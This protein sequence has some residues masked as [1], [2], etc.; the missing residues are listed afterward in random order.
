MNILVEKWSVGTPPFDPSPFKGR[1]WILGKENSHV[2]PLTALPRKRGRIKRGGANTPS[3]QPI[4]Q[5]TDS[6][7]LNHAWL[8]KIVSMRDMILGNLV[9]VSQIPSETFYERERAAF[10]LERL[11][12]S[13]LM[14]A[15]LDGS[16]NVIGILKGKSTKKRIVLSAS[17]DTYFD[18][19]VDHNVSVTA[20][21]ANGAGIANNSMGLTALLSLPD[22]I[23]KLKLEFESDLIFLATT[24]SLGKGDLGGMRHFFRTF[25]FELSCVLNIAGT[26][27]GRVDHYSQS[28]VRGDVSCIIEAWNEYAENLVAHNNAILVLNRLINSLMRIPLSKHPRTIL[29]IGI[30]KGGESYST[31]CPAAGLNLYVRSEDDARTDD[32]MHAIRDCCQDIGS[33]NRARL[34]ISFFGRQRAAGLGVYPPLVLAAS[35]TVELL[36]FKPVVE[37]TNTQITVPLSEGIPSVT[38]GIT[39][40][41]KSLLPDGYVMLEPIPR[42]VMQ[43]LTLLDMIDRESCDDGR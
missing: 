17:M 22:I 6:I 20:D 39:T 31:P 10:V 19:K 11:N 25:P 27:L 13:G 9:L 32:L 41:K 42:G 2:F 18:R 15:Y 1:V 43:L 29:N 7:T 26:S 14:E 35:R 37:P 12:D 40:G 23:K 34:E 8:D 38:L 33:K 4:A 30:I 24:K 36:G 3:L 21:R 16:G 28:A 5:M